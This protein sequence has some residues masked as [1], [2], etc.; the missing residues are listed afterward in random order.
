MQMVMG[1]WFLWG[2]TE[3]FKLL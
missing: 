1:D 2:A 3:F